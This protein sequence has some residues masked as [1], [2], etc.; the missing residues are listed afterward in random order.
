MENPIFALF[1]FVLCLFIYIHITSSWKTSSDLEVYEA[2][3]ESQRQLQEICQ[4]K[5]PVLFQ[6]K[7]REAEEFAEKFRASQFEKYDNHDV[8]LKDCADYLNPNR[9]DLAVDYL[10]LSLRSARRLL[11]SDTKA[12]YFIEGNQSFL[13]ESGLEHLAQTMDTYL[14]PPLSAYAKHDIFLGSPGATTPLRYRLETHQYLYVTSGKIRVKL[15]PPK[16]TKFIPLIKDYENYEFRSTVQV[17]K[18]KSEQDNENAVILSKIKLLDV[19]VA[20]GEIL[21]I[22]A[23][24]WY[25]IQFSGDANTTVAGF[26]YDNAVNIAAQAN[27]WALYY[28]QQNNI[29]TRVAK[30]RPVIASEEVPAE[31]SESSHESSHKSNTD[32]EPRQEVHTSSGE[33][34]NEIITNAGI[35]TID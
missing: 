24:W 26:I 5:Q 33:H 20:A 19:N 17:W 35:Y 31:V 32:L 16:Y 6:I 4:V 11:S 30:T 2:D 22:P 23:Y 25:S 3:Y 34:R 15:C 13:E 29:K 8:C 28:L 14:K 18:K 9:E 1:I 12:Q 10:T 7:N 21:Y 27:H